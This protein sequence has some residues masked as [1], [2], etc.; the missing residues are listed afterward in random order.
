MVPYKDIIIEIISKKKKL[1][2]ILLLVFLLGF[3]GL[4]HRANL[5]EN[6]ELKFYS[7]LLEAATLTVI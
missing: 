2:Q 3:R 7:E 4:K 6:I 5:D 1:Q